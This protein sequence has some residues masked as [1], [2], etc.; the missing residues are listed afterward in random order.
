MIQLDSQSIKNQFESVHI[1][2]ISLKIFKFEG[3][4][5]SLLLDIVYLLSVSQIFIFY[6][7]IWDLRCLIHKWKWI[8][9]DFKEFRLF[10]LFILCWT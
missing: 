5:G 7:R 2:Y 8:F 4:G 6:D 3:V 10:R 1:L 9:Y